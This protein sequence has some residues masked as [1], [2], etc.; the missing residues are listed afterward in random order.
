VPPNC[1]VLPDTSYRRRI[2]FAQ[3]DNDFRPG[4]E[5]VNADGHSIDDPAASDRPHTIDPQIFSHDLPPEAVTHVCARL[6][7]TEVWE[8]VNT[9]PE[10]HNFHIHQTKFRL[11][12]A[13]DP[14]AP[15]GLTPQ[16]AWLDPGHLI[17]DQIQDLQMIRPVPGVDVWHDTIPVPP[18]DSIGNPGVVYIA[19]PFV[20]PEQVGTFVFHC[21]ILEHEDGGM[22]ATVQ[23]YD[24]AQ[25]S[26]TFS[27]V[28]A[29]SVRGRP[30]F[31]GTP[32]ADAIDAAERPGV[33]AFLASIIRPPRSGR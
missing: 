28:R 26:A 1:V 8:L 22:M 10:M 19:I 32:P 17:T 12:D 13:N 30:G 33:L 21:H 25:W 23:V 14:G 2:T 9:T 27:P 18:R 5:V 31:C 7:D 3:T 15:P 11:A 4:S 24:S 20:A 16:T 6:H 29:A